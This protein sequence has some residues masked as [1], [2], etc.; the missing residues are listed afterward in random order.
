MATP[1]HSHTESSLAQLQDSL[2]RSQVRDSVAPFSPLWRRR[3][4]ELNRKAASI[5]TVAD[6][7]T[8]PAM[9][10]RDVSPT[11]DPAG[12]SSLVLQAGEAGYALHAPG[13]DLRRA[14]RLRA[15]RNDDYGRV[16][17]A[18]TRATSYV[19]SGAGFTYPIASTR[20]DLDVIT[21]AGARLWELL[22]LTA[23]DVL[24]SAIEPAATTEHVAL[25]YAAMGVGAP[26]LFPGAAP[27][28]LA[29]AVRLAPPSVLALPS[30]WAPQ[31][32]DG[33]TDLASVHTALLMGAPSD[34]ERLAA[35][36]ALHRAGAASDVAILAVHAPAGARLLW[37]ECRASGGTTGLHTYPD[38]E[39]VQV[40]DPD[41]GDHTTGAGELVITQLGLRGSAL[42]RWRTADVITAIATGPCP[43]CRR[44]VPRVEGLRRK[45]LVSDIGGHPVD[46]RTISSALAGRTDVDDWRIVVG[47]RRRDGAS[48][49]TVHLLDDGTDESAAVIGA[50]TEIR[51][52]AGTLP[53]QIVLDQNEF[54]EVYGERLSRRIL[55]DS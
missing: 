6:L 27:A 40:V 9:G 32:L 3:F 15:T 8:V 36:H 16:V 10:E 46:L 24:I 53:T 49:V 13:P 21:R 38:L 44:M 55:I 43:S 33:I 47:H 31:L 28:D 4:S 51:T 17:D 35:A 42:L 34:A 20:A 48:R 22:G 12:M 2:V 39:V 37:G 54:A 50:A 5:R 45:A 52:V 19:F 11:G 18:D 1:W 14:I 30:A 26:A 23:N 7:E 25:Q 41:T 29:G